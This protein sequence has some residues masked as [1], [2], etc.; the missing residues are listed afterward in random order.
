MSTKSIKCEQWTVNQLASKVSNRDII[1]PKYQRKRKW[2]RF[3]TS[4]NNPNDKEYIDFLY[5][6]ADGGKELSI[7]QNGS[8]IMTNIDGNNR[9]N[10]II[11]YL[12]RPFSIRTELV[13]KLKHILLVY[14]DENITN[15]I[16]K[17]I[18]SMSYDNL[19]NFI[20]KSYF[21]EN[22]HGELYNSHLK[23]KRDEVEDFF[24]N[25]IAD[26][27]IDRTKRFDEYVKITVKIYINYTTAE[28]CELFTDINKHGGNLTG[29]EML[30][31]KLYII[32]GLVINDSRLIHDLHEIAKKIYHERANDEVLPC[33][34]YDNDL[35]AYDFLVSFQ[36]HLSNSCKLLTDTEKS[37][38]G[39]PIFFKLYNMLYDGFDGT[40]TTENINN[41]ITLNTRCVDIINKIIR[42]I[43]PPISTKKSILAKLKPN[44]IYLVFISI[45]GYIKKGTSEEEIINSIV[46]TLLYHFF[47]DDMDKTNEKYKNYKSKYTIW[48]DAGG[49]YI[50]NR[51]K[52]YL[53]NPSLFSNNF[54]RQ[55][56]NE[57][58]NDLVSENI[59]SI[60]ISSKSKNRRDRKF[61]ENYLI[62]NYLKN[63]MP[64]EYL[65]Q[66]QWIEHFFP[67]SSSWEAEIDI[68]RLGNI[69]PIIED[70]NRKRGNRHIRDYGRSLK[71]GSIQY[72]DVKP[73]EDEYDE[74]VFHPSSGKKE[75]PVIIN[76]EKYNTICCKNETLLIDLFLNHI[77]NI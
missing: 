44:N 14:F 64:M 17:I 49:K 8:L 15:D 4:S 9:I 68:D 54:T 39:M 16:I 69:F 18:N 57:L 61:F 31:S 7:G 38:N 30:A 23:A 43:D 1:K 59:K 37:K 73:S 51:A 27:K 19:M 35:N 42:K 53:N 24:F 29:T 55:I 72:I 3:P 70:I 74:I 58:L 34:S 40:F 33:Y 71:S 77:F 66:N 76:N 21:I 60:N 75:N 62:S 10:C 32:T 2:D 45:I 5:K 26:M 56:M 67:F 13:D 25:L 11:N 63:K 28:L 65:N 46:I 50:D 6:H 48:F 36:K 41:F 22:G 47:V 52:D 12:N 20:Y